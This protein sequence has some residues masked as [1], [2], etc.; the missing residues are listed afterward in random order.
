MALQLAT[1]NEGLPLTAPKRH[2]RLRED[3]LAITLA[4]QTTLELESMLKILLNELRHAVPIDGMGY[5][6]NDY[7]LAYQLDGV[8]RHSCSYRLELLKQPLGEITFSRKRRFNREDMARLERLLVAALYPLN[9]ALHYRE[10]LQQAQ[11]DA[12]TGVANRHAFNDTLLRE[13]NRSQRTQEPLSLMVLDIDHFKRVN[14]TFGH[15]VG[16]E[17]LCRVASV[18]E[19]TIRVTDRL[20]RYGGEEFVAILP[21]TSR[22]GAVVI[23]ERIRQ[24]VAELTLTQQQKP[25]PVTISIGVSHYRIGEASAA[26]FERADQALYRAK[27]GGRDRVESEN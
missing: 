27:N 17:V 3:S 23:A 15:Q 26:I 10:A 6:H 18:I 20:F 8:G 7:G 19:Q 16:D 25:L 11:C 22:E 21:N 1:L 13:L 2:S 5:R 14:D 4:L 24:A 12:L 9:N